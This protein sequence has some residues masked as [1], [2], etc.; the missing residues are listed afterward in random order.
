M[1][2]YVYKTIFIFILFI[3]LFSF[4][5]PVFSAPEEIFLK[6]HS[7]KTFDPT[8]AVSQEQIVDLSEAAKWAPSSRND[9][10]WNFIFCDKY[11]TPEAYLKVLDSLNTSNQK[12]AQ[13]APLLVVIVARTK[14]THKGKQNEWADYD[15]GAA[16]IS[17]A[18]QAS[19]M[20]L[21]AHQIG[22]LIKKKFVKV[23]IC[24]KNMN[25]SRSW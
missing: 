18:L 24:L 15:T 14:E 7:G 8:Q 6:R 19:E 10:P 13:E 21:M 22:G 2:N 3:L 1:K 16:A 4:I 25:H 9:Q 23:F 12:W 5:T 11:T 20:G 17:M